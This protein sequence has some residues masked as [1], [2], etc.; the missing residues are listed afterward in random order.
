MEFGVY[1]HPKKS[2]FSVLF[3][4]FKNALINEKNKISTCNFK[5]Y[6]NIHLVSYFT[7]NLKKKVTIIHT[8]IMKA[9]R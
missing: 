8:Q 7:E 2:K 9:V 3:I 6:G 4:F 5:F 1:H